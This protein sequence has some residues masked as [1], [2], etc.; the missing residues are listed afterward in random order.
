MSAPEARKPVTAPFRADDVPW[1][2]ASHGKR[3]GTRWRALGDH[4]GATRIGTAIEELAPG[5]Q[6]NPFHFHL[7]EEEHIW[8]LEGRCT[9]RLGDRRYEVSAGD[10]MVF[11]AGRQAGHC[12]I[13][14]SGEVC[15]FFVLGERNPNEIAVYPDSNKVRVRS[16][17]ENYRRAPLDYWDGEPGESV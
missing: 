10:Y 7:L 3:F 16:L 13:N 14:D 2:E 8:I 1:Q 6:S 5:R 12:L 17:G 9:L 15:R 11:P 4:G